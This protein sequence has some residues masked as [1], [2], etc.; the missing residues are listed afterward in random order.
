VKYNWTV[1]AKDD[2]LILGAG[3]VGLSI[4]ISLLESNPKLKVRIVEKERELG[5]HASGRNSGV[6]HAGFYYSPDSL[7]AKFCKDGNRELRKLAAK[8]DIPVLD[9]GKIVVTKD[10]EQVTRLE[11]LFERGMR[12]GV[13]VELLD[14]KNLP[15][16]EPLARTSQ[17]FLWSPTTAISNP[18]LIIR[19]METDFNS[20]GGILEFSKQVEIVEENNEVVDK[21]KRFSARHYINATGSFSDLIAKGVGEA[22]DYAMI[23]FMG[24]YRSIS[25]DQLPLRTLV[26]PVPHP[27]NPFLGV[28][29]TLTIDGRV[30]IGPTALPIFGREQYSPISGWS[31]VDVKQGITGVISVAAGEA[32]SVTEI[33]KS[34]IPNIRL[35]NLI[36]EGAKLVPQAANIKKWMKKPPG[37]RAQLVHLPSGTLVQDFKVITYKNSTHILNAVSPGWTCSLPFGRYIVDQIYSPKKES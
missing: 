6:L 32:H 16:Y 23:P 1:A 37:I 2:F 31:F 18:Q 10:E 9:V 17:K 36:T 14:E 27:I 8:F 13:D 25:R 19:A 3:V 30:K 28:H 35:K 24:Q 20:K 29:L 15:K 12:N 5:A 7:K 33:L 11:E 22:E 26:Y 21:S 34:E 4:G